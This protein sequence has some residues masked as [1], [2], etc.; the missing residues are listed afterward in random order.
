MNRMTLLVGM[1]GIDGI[2][3]AADKCMIEF[4]KAENEYPDRAGIRK[5]VPLEEHKVTYAFAGDSITVAVGKDLTARLEN[6]TFDFTNIE[7]SLVEIAKASRNEEI[8]KRMYTATPVD[9]N[10]RRCLLIV[11][12]GHQVSTPQLWKLVIEHDSSAWP[13]SGSVV[14]GARSN[15][16]RFFECYFQYGQSIE[17]LK[18]LAAHIILT[19]KKVDSLCID[20]LDMV[21]FDAG[22]YRSIEGDELED[23]RRSSHKLDESIRSQLFD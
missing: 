21:V 9:A 12:Y 8:A 2:V 22:G 15:G 7:T 13:V 20:G 19:G 17:K 1:V 4:G 23:L 16:A 14:G 11:F 3:L 10:I 6:K 5:I 18:R